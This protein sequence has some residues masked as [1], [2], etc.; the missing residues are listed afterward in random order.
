MHI[1]RI[2]LDTDLR[3]ALVN[4]LIISLDERSRR[5]IAQV[6]RL[7]PGADVILFNNTG[8]EYQAT[9]DQ[10][11]KHQVTVRV[12]GFID[13]SAESPQNII[14]L[15]GISRGERMDY[16]LQKATEL[17]ITSITP[18]TTERCGVQLDEVRSQKRWLHWRGVIISACEQCGRNKLPTLETITPFAQ[19]LEQKT[20]AVDIRLVLNP[21]AKLGLKTQLT[22]SLS[23]AGASTCVTV[24][25]GPEGGLSEQ[26]IQ[27]AERSGFLSVTLGPRILRTETAGLAA[28]A[29]IQ[30]ICGDY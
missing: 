9:C 29:A 19:G 26:E 12:T 13:R 21:E 15:Q 22:N 4:E 3:T 20:D 5:H 2:F 27:L 17:G 10:V 8:G 14:L 25:I 1:P 16:T 28:I 30:T 7:K 24:L 6:L 11:N 18:V 23:T